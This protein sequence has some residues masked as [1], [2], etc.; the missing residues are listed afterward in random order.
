MDDLFTL[1]RNKLESI[2]SPGDTTGVVEVYEIEKGED[3]LDRIARA[4]CEALTQKPKKFES[5]LQWSPER[6]KFLEEYNAASEEE[7]R[8]MLESQ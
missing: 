1:F 5:A 7:R 4:M 3:A 2:T 6:D 8:N